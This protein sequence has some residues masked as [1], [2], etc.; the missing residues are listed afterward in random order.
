MHNML[1]DI[2]IILNFDYLHHRDFIKVRKL[3]IFTGPIDEFFGFELGHL[4]YRSQKREHTYLP[5]VDYALPCVQVNNP[6]LDGGLH[7][8]TVEWK[9]MMPRQYAE[10]IKGTV[11]T[12][13]IPFSPNTTNDY[14]YPF[15]DKINTCLYK[16]YRE[17]A[18]SI[19]DLL[20]CGRLGEYRYYDMDQAIERAMTLVQRLFL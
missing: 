1:K 17:Y 10:C 20:I 2:P 4:A 6:S 9:Y 7:I 13:E 14:E 5:E 12:K 19:P 16:R 11:L 8:R 3:L 18:E 15:S